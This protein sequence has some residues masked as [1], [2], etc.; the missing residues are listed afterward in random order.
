MIPVQPLIAPLFDTKSDIECLLSLSGNSKNSHDYIQFLFEKNGAAMPF[1]D[2]L[3]LGVFKKI[4]PINS[5]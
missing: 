2:F 4:T 3:R 5:K 1:K